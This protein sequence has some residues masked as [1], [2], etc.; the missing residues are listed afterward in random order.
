MKNYV[1]YYI[2]G[3]TTREDAEAEKGLLLWTTKKPGAFRRFLNC[4][5]LGIYWVDKQRTQVNAK[6]E[7]PDVQLNKVRWTKTDEAGKPARRTRKPKE[8]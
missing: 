3:A 8:E 1:G 5:L 2:I 4:T 6:S 7:N